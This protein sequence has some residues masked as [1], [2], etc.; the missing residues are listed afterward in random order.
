[1]ESGDE[2]AKQMT[3]HQPD[4]IFRTDSR[5][6]TRLNTAQPPSNWPKHGWTPLKADAAAAVLV[7]TSDPDSGTSGALDDLLRAKLHAHNSSDIYPAP[8]KHSKRPSLLN[9]N[10][11]VL[12]EF[13]SDHVQPTSL[14]LPPEGS[15]SL[16]AL[17]SMLHSRGE[18]VL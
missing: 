9:H 8:S 1:M 2:Y 15:F 7:H 11:L 12:K 14:H 17:A 4:I 16:N 10:G 6:I 13:P 3:N 5:P 18:P